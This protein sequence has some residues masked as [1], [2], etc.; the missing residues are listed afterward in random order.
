MLL[1][2]LQ[3]DKVNMRVREK[4]ALAVGNTCLGDP[5]YPHRY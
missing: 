4:A 2:I 5:A 1:A 3:S